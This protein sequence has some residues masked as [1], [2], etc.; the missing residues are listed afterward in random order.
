MGVRRRGKAFAVMESDI[1]IL[2]GSLEFDLTLATPPPDWRSVADRANTY[3]FVA[4]SSSGLLR[5]VD[6]VGC[7]EYLLGG[8]YEERLAQDG[9]DDDEGLGDLDGV[10]EFWVD[11]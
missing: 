11:W 10:E 8:E 6:G 2:P 7:R 5:T 3:A 9:Y 1:L 4:D